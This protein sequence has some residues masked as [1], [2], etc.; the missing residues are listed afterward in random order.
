MAI[1]ILSFEE[2]KPRGV[3]FSKPHLN[4]MIRA[5]DFP[6]P[7]KLGPLTNGWLEEEIDQWLAARITA[8][9]QQSA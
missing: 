2:L 7:V 6:R 5:G 4:R 9:D 3:P 1:V 8:R